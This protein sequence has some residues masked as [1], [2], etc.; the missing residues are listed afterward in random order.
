M[1]RICFPHWILTMQALHLAVVTWYFFLYY[2]NIS[3]EEWCRTKS[4]W[5][6]LV[7][8]IDFWQCK[9]CT[10]QWSRLVGT[11]LGLRPHGTQKLPHPIPQ[12]GRGPI[13]I[14]ESL[15]EAKRTQQAQ[16]LKDGEKCLA[17]PYYTPSTDI[18]SCFAVQAKCHTH[19]G[20]RNW[21]ESDL[22][23]DESTCV[24]ESVC[25]VYH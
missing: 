10:G 21:P 13:S 11:R 24:S 4:S 1:G 12:I 3:I 5:G 20:L 25:T 15:P 7:S 9:A 14:M 16:V 6:E 23:N 19:K 22:S 18:M 2:I 8:H 17:P